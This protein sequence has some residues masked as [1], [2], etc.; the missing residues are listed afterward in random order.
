M[1]WS[2]IFILSCCEEDCGSL[3][4]LGGNIWIHIFNIIL[5]IW[6]LFSLSHCPP[7]WKKQNS[8]TLVTIQTIVF[9]R[10]NC[11]GYIA[12][13][14]IFV[15]IVFPDFPDFSCVYCFLSYLCH[16][17]HMCSPI[18]QWRLGNFHLQNTQERGV[19]ME[20]YVKNETWPSQLS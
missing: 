10:K 9:S 13:S 6:I 11:H 5:I 14:F 17:A 3:F 19:C 8:E 7:H 16:L 15:S 1:K 2:I 12:I 20:Q 18:Q 4:L